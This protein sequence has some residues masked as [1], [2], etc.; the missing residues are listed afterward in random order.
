MYS[1]RKN[2]TTV[3]SEPLALRGGG[4]ETPRRSAPA[5]SPTQPSGTAT[6][7]DREERE[8]SRSN[9]CDL[10]TGGRSWS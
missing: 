7:G 3:A 10:S 8:P 1:P 9:R 6:I 5:S 4:Q 2:G